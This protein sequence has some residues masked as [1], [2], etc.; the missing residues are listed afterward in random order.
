MS[1]YSIKKIDDDR[2]QVFGWAYVT[3]EDGVHV[4]DDSREFIK[5]AD[6]EPAAY[7][8]VIESRASNDM[9]QIPVTGEMIESFVVTKEKLGLMGIESD[10]EGWWVGFQLDNKSF[11]AVKRGERGAFSIE[12][13]AERVAA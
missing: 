6:L 12:G 10:T 8:F 13:I 7:E 11:Q 1:E 3:Q 9:H 2:Q 4:I 5:T